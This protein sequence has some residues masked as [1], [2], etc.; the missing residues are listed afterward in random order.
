LKIHVNHF[1]I[2]V[3][4]APQVMLLP[5]D[6]DEDLIDVERVTIAS[7]FSF[8]TTCKNGTKLD[9]PEADRFSTDGDTSLS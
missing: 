3:Y 4:S 1:A 6:L 2:L 9:A 5:V 8:Q 7:V